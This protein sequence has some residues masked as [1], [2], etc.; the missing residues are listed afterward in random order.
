MQPHP[1]MVMVLAFFLYVLSCGM[2]ALFQSQCFTVGHC[3]PLKMIPRSASG[4]QTIYFVFFMA[5]RF[6]G[7][8]ISKY[9]HPRIIIL[10]SIGFCLAGIILILSVG[11]WSVPGLF[12]GVGIT[13]FFLSFQ[14]ASG[15]SWLA[16]NMDMTGKNSS[17]V[18]LGASAGFLVSP[19]LAGFMEDSA[20]GVMAVFYLM[21]GYAAA[22]ALV[23]C[24]LGFLIRR[25]VGGQ[26]GRI[27]ISI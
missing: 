6:S 21:L 2:E 13:G 22:Q 10:V 5:G 12:A 19:P 23:F 9:L 11:S 17:I 24:S 7:V 26:G 15:F 1:R 25:K 20:G 4:L 8:I 27:N 14:F 16:E 3:G 18:F